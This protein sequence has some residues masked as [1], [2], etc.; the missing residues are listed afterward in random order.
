MAA[1]ATGRS[2]IRNVR[3]LRLKESDRLA[4]VAKELT[5][6]GIPVKELPDGL[7]I[8][9]GN[10]RSP[11]APIEAHD[12]HRIAMAFAL[13]G[14]CV[15]EVEIHGAEAVAKSFPSF[16]EEFKQFSDENI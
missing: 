10:V 12:D 2:H 8:D 13:M 1:F 4:V 14:L 6:F 15:E 5:K 16:W 3:H 9:G 7:V 11:D